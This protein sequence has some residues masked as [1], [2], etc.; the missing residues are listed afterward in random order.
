M[1]AG[2]CLCGKIT[3]E[4]DSEP[5]YQV[6]CCC[7]D[8]QRA[9]GSSHVPVVGVPKEHFKIKGQPKAFVS[10]GGSGKN[11]IRHFCPD[12]GSLLFGTPE[13]NDDQVTIYAGTLNPDFVFKPTIAINTKAKMHWEVFE[14]GIKMIEGMPC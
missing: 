13:S 14:S 5:L 7:M 8:C 10:I 4:C 11:A 6:I 2:H 12:C 3:Y 9:S 1:I